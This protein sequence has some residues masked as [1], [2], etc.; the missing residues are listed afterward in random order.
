M[1]KTESNLCGK[2]LICDNNNGYIQKHLKQQRAIDAS[3]RS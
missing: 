3:M 2:Y 1:T